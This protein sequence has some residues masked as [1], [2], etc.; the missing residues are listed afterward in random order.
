MDPHVYRR[1]CLQISIYI[2]CIYFF[3][4]LIVLTCI[5]RIQHFEKIYFEQHVK[6]MCKQALS[7]VLFMCEWVSEN[8]HLQHHRQPLCTW[9]DWSRSQ[10]RRKCLRT[11]SVDT[12]HTITVPSAL[13]EY[14]TSWL[15]EKHEAWAVRFMATEDVSLDYHTCIYNKQFHFLSH[16]LG[17]V[18]CH[19]ICMT[20]VFHIFL[21]CMVC[22]QN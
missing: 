4:F 22:S 19:G 17:P 5:H 1:A 12:S 15:S 10:D 11:C 8:G 7:N 3:L 2:Y 14:A 9:R 13:H 20:R 21:S 6:K 18:T 16:P